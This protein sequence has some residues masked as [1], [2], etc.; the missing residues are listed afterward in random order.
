M[1][2]IDYLLACC[3]FIDSA[4]KMGRRSLAVIAATPVGVKDTGLR[5]LLQCRHG[6][7]G[8]QGVCEERTPCQLPTPPPLL[9]IVATGGDHYKGR[10]A[11]AVDPQ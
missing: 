6:A 10:S 9:L 3:P 1:L 5:G 2:P 8:W 11:L 4:L 7:D